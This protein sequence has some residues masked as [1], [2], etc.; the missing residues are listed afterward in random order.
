MNCQR[1]TSAVQRFLGLPPSPPPY[2]RRSDHLP[3]L[4]EA[5]SGPKEVALVLIAALVGIGG[6]SSASAVLCEGSGRIDITGEE[7]EG[8]LENSSA[9]LPRVLL[10]EMGTLIIEGLDRSPGNGYGISFPFDIDAETVR[11][12]SS[13]VR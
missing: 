12:I 1:E 11:E 6:G 2:H 10:E 8:G 7:Q 4:A 5:T 3:G 13:F 9:T